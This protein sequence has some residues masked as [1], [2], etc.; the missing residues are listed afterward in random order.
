MSELKHTFQAKSSKLYTSENGKQDHL[1]KRWKECFNADM[2]KTEAIT[3]LGGT[4]T[5]VARAIGITPQAV[6]DWPAELSARVADR[7]YA[8][9]ARLKEAKKPKG[10][11]RAAG[12]VA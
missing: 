3:M 12:V 5:A 10:R 6:N 7:V 8:A 2:L 1:D 11:Q 4:P 9:A